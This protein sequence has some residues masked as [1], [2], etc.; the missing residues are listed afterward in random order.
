MVAGREDV[1]Q[2]LAG[3][4]RADRQAAAERLGGGQRVGHH[5]GVLV[6][7]QRAGPA[8][9]ALD[10][11]EDERGAV[12]VARGA[13]GAQDVLAEL[14]DAALALDRLEQHR[15]GVLVDGRGD[16]L[17][18]RLDRDEARH[19]RREGRLLGLLGVAESEP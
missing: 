12:G 9:P 4:E 10:L 19:E 18:G 11:V 15:G 13:R 2:A 3:D 14:V 5:A 6:G 8:Q 17:R 1:G 7:P 16:R